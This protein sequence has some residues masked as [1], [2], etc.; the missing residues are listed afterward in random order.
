[1]HLKKNI[2]GVTPQKHLPKDLKQIMYWELFPISHFSK[3]LSVS[4]RWRQWNDLRTMLFLRR[5]FCLV[6]IVFVQMPRAFSDR[7]VRRLNQL[8]WFI[9]TVIALLAV[10]DQTLA[11]QTNCRS[12]EPGGSH[13][14]NQMT[15]HCEY[16]A[17][18]G[19][20]VCRCKFQWIQWIR[21]N[22][23]DRMY[24][25]NLYSMTDWDRFSI[26]WFEFKNGCF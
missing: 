8:G 20:L 26:S 21:S 9:S 23:C 1:M 16:K 2:N 11:N 19:W 15:R 12:I 25:L 5:V 17:E 18:V 22:N 14:C 3:I 4:G 6:P 13:K 10:L 24:S 7:W